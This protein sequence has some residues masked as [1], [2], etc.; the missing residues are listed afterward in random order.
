MEIIIRTLVKDAIEKVKRN[1]L[2]QNVADQVMD[3]IARRYGVRGNTLSGRPTQR[4]EIPAKHLFNA[5]CQLYLH[6]VLQLNHIW[7]IDNLPE[8][9]L[10]ELKI[11]RGDGVDVV[12][13]DVYGRFN[14]ISCI[15]KEDTNVVTPMEL[16]RFS[17]A[18]SSYQQWNKII[19]FTNAGV[20]RRSLHKLGIMLV[21]TRDFQHITEDEWTDMADCS[22]LP[23]PPAFE[24]STAGPNPE[25]L[26]RIWLN[27]YSTTK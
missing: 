16:I 13:R 5:F 15:F 18:C 1:D 12:A 14:A 6:H 24:V 7:L 21:G 17:N 3:E 2:N 20:V 27:R 22:H 26:R 11:R 4:P 19:L 10:L 9:L 8:D 23:P 25:E